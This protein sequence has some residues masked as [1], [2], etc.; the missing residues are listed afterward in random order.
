VEETHIAL[1]Q[2]D[3]VAKVA[4][5]ALPPER[6]NGP[7]ASLNGVIAGALGLLISVLIALISNW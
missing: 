4:G 7:R 2:N 3:Q 5:Q 6:P 1:T